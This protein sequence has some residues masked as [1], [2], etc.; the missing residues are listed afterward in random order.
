MRSTAE[1]VEVS[2]KRADAGE[3]EP[4]QLEEAMSQAFYYE[5]LLHHGR[6]GFIWQ[7]LRAPRS[8]DYKK[9]ET[10]GYDERL[11]MPKFPFEQDDIDNWRSVTE[12]SF[13]PVAREIPAE[14]SMGAGHAGRHDDWPGMISERYISENNQRN[15]YLRWMEFM[16]AESWA[17]IS[18][19][20]IKARFDG[21][22]TM[23]G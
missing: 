1:E 12:A 11:R 7:K 17:D 13:S 9:T 19:E 23:A 18:I 21:T 10:K 6:P 16:N 15:F 8:Y 22:A 5:S 4:E 2:L 14:L 20:P 3:Y